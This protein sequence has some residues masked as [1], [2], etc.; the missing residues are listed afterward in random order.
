MTSRL[1]FFTNCICY[2]HIKT[3]NFTFVKSYLYFN[4]V[5]IE[6]IAE[7]NIEKRNKKLE[8]KGIDPN[9]TKMQSIANTRTSSIKNTANYKNNSNKNKSSKQEYYVNHNI[10]KNSSIADIA[11]MLNSNYDSNDS[12]SDET[13]E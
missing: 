11:N 8:K 1:D 7:K 10:N 6:T 2:I 3:D 12:D 9:S 4:K 13:E 5:G